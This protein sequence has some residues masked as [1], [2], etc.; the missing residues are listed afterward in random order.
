[1]VIDLNIIYL[2]RRT[3]KKKVA[4]IYFQRKNPWLKLKLQRDFSGD[5]GTLNLRRLKKRETAD[6][7]RDQPFTPSDKSLSHRS[8]PRHWL[9]TL[10]STSILDGVVCLYDWGRTTWYPTSIRRLPGKRSGSK[11]KISRQWLYYE[12][13]DAHSAN[14]FP[15][16]RHFCSQCPY[17]EKAVL[18][19]IHH[20]TT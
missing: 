6:S 20:G 7:I 9:N 13:F 10:S 19:D 17:T 1:M 15:L 2:W 11:Q 16:R 3:R 8:A 14:S 4:S 12:W 18:T 5:S